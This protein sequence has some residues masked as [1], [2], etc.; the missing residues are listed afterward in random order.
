MQLNEFF[1]TCLV[2]IQK[3]EKSSALLSR[4]QCLHQNVQN[5]AKVNLSLFIYDANQTHHLT[6][7]L[8]I[9]PPTAFAGNQT[10][11]KYIIYVKIA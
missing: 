3:N 6:F 1:C 11:P 9:K 5:I 2:G 7:T 10:P 8:R 4:V